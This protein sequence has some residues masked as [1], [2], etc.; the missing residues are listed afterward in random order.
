[1]TDEKSSPAAPVP[2]TASLVDQ[3]ARD[4]ENNKI[5]NPEAAAPTHTTLTPAQTTH[6]SLYTTHPQQQPAHSQPPQPD[7]SQVYMRPDLPQPLSGHDVENFFSNLD[8]RT[9]QPVVT[10]APSSGLM[11][12][13]EASLA[14]LTNAQ[15]GYAKS[16]S[17]YPAAADIYKNSN[18]FA[19]STTPGL[20][21]SHYSV[22][23]N[24]SVV[25]QISKLFTYVILRI[26]H[27]I[28]AVV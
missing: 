28:N 11:G 9:G 16:G 4:V 15:T 14:S 27:I 7:P 25:S 23:A 2:Q 10:V 19:T 17:H 3:S 20:L 22:S 12:Y 24:R 21:T 13:D 1:M 6:P 8:G 5:A 26:N 18:M